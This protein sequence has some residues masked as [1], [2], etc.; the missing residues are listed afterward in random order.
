M[1]REKVLAF[2][3]SHKIVLIERMTLAGSASLSARKQRGMAMKRLDAS[4]EDGA[5]GR[6]G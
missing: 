4:D 1:F 5:L 3:M 2:S 6:M